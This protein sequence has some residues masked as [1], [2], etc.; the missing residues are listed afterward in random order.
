MDVSS[1]RLLALAGAAAF[2]LTLIGNV[3]AGVALGA[4]AGDRLQLTGPAG[5][6]W[7]GRAAAVQAGGLRLGATSWDLSVLALLTGRLA[8]DV[9]TRIGDGDLT[10]AV[11]VGLSGAMACTDC[12]YEGPLAGLRGVL[13]ALRTLDGRA[14]VEFTALELRDGW[15]TRAVGTAKLTR[16]PMTTPGAPPRAGAPTAD[17]EAT[18]NADPVPAD[19]LVEVA[20]QDAGGPVEF[21]ARLAVTP[22]GNYEMSGRAKARPGAPADM[23]N[24]LAVLGPRAADGSTEL[25][26]SG[27]F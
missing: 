2:L 11:S 15:P 3:P 4:L 12:R 25:S 5:T 9:T 16:V 7:N 1:P 22:P 19:G 27:S 10:G 14:T 17:F 24:A 26:M 6:L 8:A 23:T 20:V 21:T 13:P 18:V